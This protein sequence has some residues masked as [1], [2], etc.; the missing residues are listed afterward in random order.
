M[1]S[2]AAPERIFPYYLATLRLPRGDGY[3]RGRL[4]ASIGYKNREGN[5]LSEPQRTAVEF[6]AFTVATPADFLHVTEKKTASEPYACDWTTAMA[7]ITSTIPIPPRPPSCWNWSLRS[8]TR[9]SR[10]S[11]GF[12]RPFW[13][14]TATPP[15][16]PLRALLRTTTAPAPWKPPIFLTKRT[17]TEKRR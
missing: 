14:P 1:D 12:S 3:G 8:R 5:W 16:F 9:P 7:A 2:N 4:H 15:T 13:K 10:P 17:V 11:T 6:P